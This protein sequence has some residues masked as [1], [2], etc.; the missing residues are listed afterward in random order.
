[1]YSV[2]D[3]VLLNTKY[4]PIRYTGTPKFLPRYVGP[5]TIKERI[6]QVAY[7]LEIPV[8]YKIHPVFHVSLLEP[9]R[10][11]G[12]CQPPPLPIV[13]DGALE[14]EIE[15]ILSH[16]QVKQGKRVRFDYLVAWQGYGPEHNSWEPQKD[17]DDT[18]ALDKYLSRTNV[19][20][21]PG[22][23]EQV[24]GAPDRKSVV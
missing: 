17:L 12:R 15:R 3:K 19:H 23:P 2:G 16:R 5:F 14:Y 24:H 8:N 1:M 4:L 9:Y 21:Q 13:V 18:V 20:P 11:D 6:G 10:E 22:E 7:R